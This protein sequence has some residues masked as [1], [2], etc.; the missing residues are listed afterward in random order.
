L[1]WL[2]GRYQLSALLVTMVLAALT[3]GVGLLL[4]PPLLHI[5]NAD[6]P[7]HP[8]A[9]W[10]LQ[11]LK[12][13][14]ISPTAGAL[15]S[16]FV[17][18]V[19]LRSTIVYWRDQLT[20]QVQHRLVDALR[21]QSFTALLQAEWRWLSAK[22][23]SDHANMLLADVNRVG[24][25]LHFGM[26]C[27]TG[28]ITLCAYVLTAL[29]LS[30]SLTLLAL[31]SGGA[32]LGILAHQRR[33]AL[34]LGLDLSQAQSALHSVTQETLA[35]LKVAKIL[36]IT[37]SLTDRLRRAL[38][39]LR[40][41]QMSFHRSTER[42][43]LWFQVGGAALLAAYVY[44]GLY[45]WKTPVPVLL[46]LTLIFSRLIPLFM[47]THQQWHRCLHAW[48]ALQDI[49]RL[50]RECQAHAEPAAPSRTNEQH[51]LA[52]CP[53]ERHVRLEH[54]G[55]S[56]TDRER[57]ALSSINLE[58]ATHTTTAIMG[59]SGAGKS[60]LADVLMGLITPDE[61]TVWLDGIALTGALR[62]TWRRC[63]SYVPQE[64]FLFHAS[65]RDNLFWG[66]ADATEAEMTEALQQAA[67]DFVFALP[68]GLDTVIGDGGQRLSGGER[69]RI[70]L[71]RALLQRPALLILDEATSAL[72]MDNEAK[73]RQAIEQLHGNLT[74]V[75]IGHRLPTLEHADQV[76]I[77][78][79][80]KVK[81][82]G[83]WNDVRHQ[84]KA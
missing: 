20:Q 19:A 64:V 76:L 46:T 74:M 22:R 30:W 62:H 24:A 84:F 48:P 58:L 6:T 43:R 73:I 42:S 13:W 40:D 78:E 2:A 45:V 38:R 81:A 70:A 41:N 34:K 57:A 65:V 3:E 17:A 72:D 15:L 37:H 44:A 5:L 12:S 32:V 51:G 18:L 33:A 14:G 55:V 77:L 39:Q 69:Q 56:F 52:P 61:G 49:Q 50:L 59:A 27:V 66:K 23:Q 8:M 75:V 9:Q 29:A 35:G 53:I 31:L 60:T 7:A 79:S 54:V 11:V 67:A 63:V 68:Q 25:G 26:A 36:G 80:G 16:L 83:T 1:A 10:L 28:V 71:A 21:L 82:L 47:G 4:L